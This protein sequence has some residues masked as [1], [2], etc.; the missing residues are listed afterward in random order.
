M[1]RSKRLSRKQ[2]AFIDDLFEG[3][4]DEQEILEKY[5]VGR[6]LY[7]KWLTDGQFADELN[8]RVAGAYRQCTL[9]LA[10]SA[11]EVAQKLV[12]LTKSG[13]GETVRKACL[14]IIAM[15]PSAALSSKNV[16]TEEKVEQNSPIS[17]STASRLLAVLAGGEAQ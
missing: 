1:P 7:H 12:D 11:S 4:S 17:P 9:V 5:N 3:E 13:K 14:D 16:K 10:R 6:L 15:N 8:R 2:L